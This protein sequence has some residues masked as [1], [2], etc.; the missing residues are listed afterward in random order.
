MLRLEVEEIPREGGRYFGV[1][2]MAQV[3]ASSLLFFP[4]SRGEK[5][6]QCSPCAS[7]CFEMGG[8]RDSCPSPFLFRV[9]M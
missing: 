8:K 7:K 1:I 5:T 6:P 2:F 9:E 3:R 4:L